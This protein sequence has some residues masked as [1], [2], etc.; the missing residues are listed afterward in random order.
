MTTVYGAWV[1]NSSTNQRMRLAA[2][3]NVPSPSVG[4]TSVT[5]TGSC[6]VGARYGF[7]DS[8][9]TFTR[10]GTLIPGGS[11]A[12]SIDVATDGEDTIFTFSQSVTLTSSAQSKTLSFSLTGVD[13]VGASNTATVSMTVTIPAEVTDPPPDPTGFTVT[14]HADYRH[15]LD[16]SATGTITDFQIGRLRLGESWVYPATPWGTARSWNDYADLT[17]DYVRW[18]IR[19]RNASGTSNWVYSDFVHTTPAAASGVTISRSGSD[20]VVAWTINAAAAESQTL[21]VS[22]SSDGGSTWGAWADI[23]GHVGFSAALSTRTVSGL[24]ASEQHKVRVVSTVTTPTTLTAT[25]AA[26]DPL[27]LLTAP[28]APTP[29][30][31][32]GVQSTAEAAVFQWD[33]RPLDTTAQTA[34]EVE[35]SDDDWSTSTTETAT[36]AESLS[37]ASGTWSPG[38]VQ[39]KA[40]T[41]GAHADWSDWSSVVSFTVADPPS[42]TI[43]TP[44]D[45]STWTSNKLTLGITFT[46]PGSAS[47]VAWGAELATGG[48]TI[49][50]L[51]GDAATD[52]IAFA[53]TVDDATDYTATVWAVSGSGLT[54]PDATVTVSVDYVD[55][56]PPTLDATWDEPNGTVSLVVGFTAPTGG[57][58]VT[59]HVYIERSDDDGATWVLIA[60]DL[61]DLAGVGDDRVPLNSTPT[62]RAVAVSSLGVEA[63]TT[64]T[65]STA[66]GRVWLASD[67]G[68]IQIRHQLTMQS[69]PTVERAIEHYL[70]DTYPT[71]HYGDG[72]PL[73]IAVSGAWL[74]DEQAQDV[75]T[76]LGA[77]CWYR[78]PVGRAFWASVESLPTSHPNSII[79]PVSL[80]VERVDG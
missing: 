12:V 73:R 57:E 28:L 59:D 70:G 5:V 26:S 62:Y 34:A 45:L 9:N 38:T 50:S 24:N 54:S 69:T 74:G 52:T 4:D 75:Q 67:A 14:R 77:D 25:S 23:S 76:V 31:P 6:R 80:T 51:T 16:W 18:A 27:V 30:A 58:A 8:S 64:T 37:V 47:M 35:W 40:R 61:P 68:R 43:D 53:T 56:L 17:D 19:A 63:S 39:W 11:G 36:T 41:K 71:A 33:H 21:Q 46:D 78:D 55:P 60:D 15:E 20:A 10:S 49:E 32:L 2:V 7:N 65:V 1:P 22:S 29:L 44:T 13:Y 72:R 48:Q 42:V 66:S 3:A 79:W